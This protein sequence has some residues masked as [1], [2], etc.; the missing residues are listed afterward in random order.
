[1]TVRLPERSLRIALAT[2][3]C[4]SGVKLLD[5]PGSDIV[6]PLV[7]IGGT[8]LVVYSEAARLRLRRANGRVPAPRSG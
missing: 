3:L 7:L 5:A 6:L 1:M 2:V 8:A 4:L